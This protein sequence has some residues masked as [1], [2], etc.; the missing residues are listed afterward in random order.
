MKAFNTFIFIV[1]AKHLEDNSKDNYA[2]QWV[3]NM[4]A[5][6]H[7]TCNMQLFCASDLLEIVTRF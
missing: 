1:N 3:Y 2:V 7:C 6:L 4:S 5:I